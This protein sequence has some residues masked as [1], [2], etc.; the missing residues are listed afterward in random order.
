MGKSLKIE[1]WQIVTSCSSVKRRKD[2]PITPSL[3]SRGLEELASSWV[4]KLNKVK[5][6]EPAIDTYGGR[7]FTDAVFASKLIGADLN[8]ISAGL[9]LVKVDEKIPNYNLTISA[10]EG[11]IA[12]WLK[13]R[14]HTSKDWWKSLNNHLHKANSLNSLVRNSSGV[15]FALPSSYIKLIENDLL[16]LSISDLKRIYIITSEAGQV[17]LSESLRE[18]SLPYDERLNGAVK[19]QGTRNDFA[20]RALRHFVE[21]VDF[22]SIHF[23]ESKAKVLAFLKAHQKPSL[24]TR[25]KASDEEIQKLIKNNWKAFNGKRDPLH[26]F[27]RDVALIACEQKRFGTL[28]NEV[29][30]YKTGVQ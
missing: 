16:S 11:S 25:E 24:P 28:W 8:V 6:L 3:S 2:T 14:G 13:D 15:I 23:S 4:R 7:S 22:K 29:K 1:N 9:G 12:G 19:F 21:E 27:L 5:S 18:R 30:A 17:L 20:Q 10:G 26:R